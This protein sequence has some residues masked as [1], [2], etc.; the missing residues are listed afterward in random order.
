MRICMIGIILMI[1]IICEGQNYLFQNQTF[2]KPYLTNP[3]F[4]G[5][6]NNGD[7]SLIYNK[8]LIGFDN[9]PNSQVISVD[10]PFSKNQ[11]GIGM[12]GFKEEN[13]AISFIGFESTFSYHIVKEEKEPNSLTAISFGLSASYNQYRIDRIGLMTGIS[14]NNIFNDESKF[15]NAYPSA[16]IGF[17]FFSH[18]FNLGFSAYNIIPNA[19]SVFTNESDIQNALVTFITSGLD[20]QMTENLKIKP[21]FIFRTQKNADYQLDIMFDVSLNLNAGSQFSLSPVFR[22]YVFEFSGKS[23]ALG[24]NTMFIKYPFRVGY[25]FDLP[26]TATINLS[27]SGHILMIGYILTDKPKM[28]KKDAKRKIENSLNK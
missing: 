23:K 14:D 1:N 4:A 5:F 13:G 28:N 9:S 6:P 3:A 18:G 19:S 8:K 16:N 7:F 12:N 25:Q 21:N 15:F 11:I 2:F 20:L 10:Y 17:N 27:N 24:L 22:N 26:L